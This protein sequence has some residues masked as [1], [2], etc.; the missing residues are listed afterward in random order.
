MEP[1]TKASEI[2]ASGRLAIILRF[3]AELHSATG[4]ERSVVYL[5]AFPSFA[6]CDIL[7]VQLPRQIIERAQTAA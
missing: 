1:S 2:A 6:S 4:A 5:E 7:T 3:R